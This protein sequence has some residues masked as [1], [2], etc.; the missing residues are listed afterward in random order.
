MMILRK[1]FKPTAL[2]FLFLLGCWLCIFFPLSH[3]GS[4]GRLTLDITVSQQEV[5]QVFWADHNE[6]YGPKRTT[7]VVLRPGRATYE[8]KLPPLQSVEKIRFD[9]ITDTGTLTVH[10]LTLGQG[11]MDIIQLT[12]VQD[13]QN[14]KEV[15]NI[16]ITSSE[17]GNLHLLATG[18]DPQLEL[19]V[20]RPG[21]R[22]LLLQ[23]IFYALLLALGPA[24]LF[25]FL[26]SSGYREKE[27]TLYPVSKRIHFSWYFLSL[28]LGIFLVLVIPLT[29]NPS[30]NSL[31]LPAIAGL[32][33]AGVYLVTFW[34]A[35]RPMSRIDVVEP[36]RW[37]W[38][39]YALPSYIIWLMYLFA[40][41]PGSMSPDSLDQWGQVLAGVTHLKDWHPASHTLTIWLLTRVWMSPAI[42]VIAQIVMLG[43][44]A[45]WCLAVLQKWGVPRYI[46]WITA[47]IFASSLVNG[48]LVITLW[49]DVIYSTSLLAL[50]IIIF[51]LVMS[52]GQWLNRTA[53]YLLLAIVLFCVVIYRHNG[54]IPALSI[55]FVLLLVFVGYRKRIFMIGLSVLLIFVAV[56]G[57]LY[58]LLDVRR[59][60][61]LSR[62]ISKTVDKIAS[63]LESK[64]ESQQLNGKVGSEEKT[65]P[66]VVSSAQKKKKKYHPV[67]ER[68][69]ASSRLWRIEPL[70]GFHRRIEY[71]NLWGK[72]RDNKRHVK[73]V[74]SNRVGVDEE[75]L[76]PQ[77]LDRI[78]VAFEKSKG[79]FWFFIWR[80]ALYL[81]VFLGC[82]AI[83]G[84]RLKSWMPLLLAFPVLFN[85][86]PTLFFVIHKSIFRYHYSIVLV[87]L[88]FSLP[89]LFLN[90]RVKP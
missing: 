15:H 70:Q 44:V 1:I 25:A 79:G 29:G 89:L 48:L 75:S 78:Y 16:K 47:I 18:E 9:P 3:V 80:P 69:L 59:G 49:K 14:L 45:G 52:R 39:W 63:M 20:S 57:P 12:T 58:H 76:L 62:E 33:G 72:Y 83:S 32:I 5:F 50:T 90:R 38:L 40:F 51:Q 77:L 88:L 11:N 34:L 7:T 19:K 37:S 26:H 21:W 73:Y 2:F 84:Y 81:Y 22:K 6:S 28:F 41:W 86:L 4:W 13:F 35:T 17:N 31:Y 74:S 66:P 54:V 65:K 68:L 71:V 46:L 85:S 55:S 67:E 43:G 87:S 82:V 60:N 23:N 64:T 24:A 53:S 36:S 56:R 10:A 30:K 8:L 61:P 42:V 27:A